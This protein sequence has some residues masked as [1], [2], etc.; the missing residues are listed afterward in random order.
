LAIGAQPYDLFG[1]PRRG[2]GLLDPTSLY[3]L[4]HGPRHLLK[5]GD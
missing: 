1:L 2:R 3:R 4:G 5:T